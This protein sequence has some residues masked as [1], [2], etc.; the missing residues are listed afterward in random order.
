MSGC[1]VSAAAR[2][3]ME[4]LVEG[5]AGLADQAASLALEEALVRARPPCPLLRIWQ[6]GAC[7]VIGRGQRVWR[8][9]NMDACAASGVP[10]LRRASGGGTVY[11]DLGNLNVS[12]VVPG[13]EPGLAA[14]LA[15]L[16][17]AVVGRLGLQASVGER[18]LF[19]GSAKVAGL[20]SQVTREGTVAHATLLVTTPPARVQAYLTPAPPDRHSLDSR[21]SPVLPLCAHD[22]ALDVAACRQALLAEAA[23][24]YGPL[25]PRPPRPAER[26]WQT[27]L[28]A[29]RY[30]QDSWHRTGQPKTSQ[31]A[32]WTTRPG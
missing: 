20:A 31:E 32:A 12:L 29:E 16:L 3:G 8:E 2:G 22:P 11:H 10:V 6:N 14:E 4:V 23:S 19:I 18:G 26:R 17:A 21:R 7:V 13:R 27:R 30:R 25:S 5:C 9:V 28:L 24:R 15:A 1:V